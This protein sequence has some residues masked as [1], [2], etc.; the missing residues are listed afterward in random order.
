MDENNEILRTLE[1]R[2][3]FVSLGP[4]RY[5]LT[6]SGQAVVNTGLMSEPA[7]AKLYRDAIHEHGVSVNIARLMVLLA[8]VEAEQERLAEQITDLLQSA[9]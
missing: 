2:N 8:V 3:L 9:G 1:E 6:L 7:L 5:E 4:G